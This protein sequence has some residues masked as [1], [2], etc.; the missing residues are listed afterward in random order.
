MV[1]Y[2]QREY[3]PGGRA[4][5][6]AGGSGITPM[7]QVAQG[8]LRNPYDA[9]K[10][11]LIYANV[12]EDDILLRKEFDAWARDHRARFKV[13][14][15]ATADV[16][17]ACSLGHSEKSGLSLLAGL[18]SPAAVLLQRLV[19]PHGSGCI[20]SACARASG[21][22]QSC[23]PCRTMPTSTECWCGELSAHPAGVLRPGEAASRV[24]GRRGV[25]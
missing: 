4:G 21:H 16:T 22:L 5:M 10:V 6:I 12:A 8:I 19:R 3:M 2:S 23:I 13:W 17:E 18:D 9:T 11:F 25:C 24:D 1:T 7:F 20:C 15:S 14:L